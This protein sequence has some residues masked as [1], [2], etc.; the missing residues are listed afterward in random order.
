MPLVAMKSTRLS[1]SDSRNMQYFYGDYRVHK[2]GHGALG[3]SGFETLDIETGRRNISY[4]DNRI[5]SNEGLKAIPFKGRPVYAIDIIK[6]TIGESDHSLVTETFYR[7]TLQRFSDVSQDLYVPAN[8]MSAVIKYDS[9]GEGMLVFPISATMSQ[10]L[11]FDA[12]S[13]IATQSRSF[14]GTG[15]WTETAAT[16]ILNQS[17]GRWL[18]GP[19]RANAD[20]V[21]Q[22]RG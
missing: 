12:T 18:M 21:R 6:P 13:G 11:A 22:Y 2:Q 4:R 14:D 15:A 17:S 16:S 1:A 8:A 10:N 9:A 5:H 7:D 3:M 19:T 20:L